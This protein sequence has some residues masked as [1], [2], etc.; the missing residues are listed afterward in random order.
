MAEPDQQIAAQGRQ[1]LA[2]NDAAS[3]SLPDCALRQIKLATSKQCHTRERGGSWRNGCMASAAVART[4]PP[5]CGSCSAAR[6]P[7]SPR[8]RTLKLPVPPGFT[9]TTEVC[10]Y[11]YANDRTY[12]PELKGEV[13]AAL[14]AIADQTGKIFGD[15]AEPLLVS[16]R[17]G[18]RASMPG[19]MDTVL[20]LGLNDE[21]VQRHRRS[22]RRALRLGHLPPLHPDVRKRGARRRA[23]RVRSRSW[24]LSARSAATP[25]TPISTPR[26]GRRSSPQYKKL[27]EDTLDTPFPQAPADQLWGAIGAVFGSWMNPR[28]DSYRKL[29]D[30]PASWGT[31]VNVQAMVFGNMG[32]SSATGRRFHA[33]S[34]D[35]REG[36]LRRVPG[37][38]AGRGRRRRHPHAAGHHGSGAAS[39]PARSSRRSKR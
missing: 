16:V 11:F 29:H 15:R 38:R 19:M 31:A 17:S 32:D 5:L 37:Q 25:T 33:Q 23:P 13:E 10:T 39:R 20:N 30:I 28:A 26:P 24:S 22:R 12:P 21:T 27:I 1:P 14:G 3:V 35:R 7:T 4:A 8:W 6:A 9:I 34:G 2:G 36:A 18:A